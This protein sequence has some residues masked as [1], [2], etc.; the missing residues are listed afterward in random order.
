MLVIKILKKVLSTVIYLL[1]SLFE[2]IYFAL[3]FIL[4]ILIVGYFVLNLP[5]YWN[6]V[7]GFFGGIGIIV[8]SIYLPT[9]DTWLDARKNKSKK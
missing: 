2:E 6:L 1:M 5:D 3:V 4:Y 7:A 9:I 8:L